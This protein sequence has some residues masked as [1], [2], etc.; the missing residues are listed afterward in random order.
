MRIFTLC[1]LILMSGNFFAQSIKIDVEWDGEE[2]YTLVGNK[3]T[4]PKTK[5]YKNNFIEIEDFGNDKYS[6][7]YIIGHIDTCAYIIMAY[8]CIYICACIFCA[9]GMFQMCNM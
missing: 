4:V 6:I 3:F 9:Q 7:L 2:S 8:M 5:N 1:S